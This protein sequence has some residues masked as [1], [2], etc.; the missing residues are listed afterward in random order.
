VELHSPRATEGGTRNGLQG[1]SRCAV[2][3]RR[4][5]E[6]V[7]RRLDAVVVVQRMADKPGHQMPRGMQGGNVRG[8]H[9]ELVDGVNE[10]QGLGVPV[11]GGL[12]LSRPRA[13]G[14]CKRTTRNGA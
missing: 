9:H 2:Q 10:L 3:R 6:H 8:A 1:A 4:V 14:Y 5:C 7:A 11:P 13:Q 12:R